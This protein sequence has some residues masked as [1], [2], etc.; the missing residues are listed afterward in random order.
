MAPWQGI[1]CTAAGFLERTGRQ[2]SLRSKK[3]LGVATFPLLILQPFSLSVR[4]RFSIMAYIV[5]DF[6]VLASA[7]P[8]YRWAL[9]NALPGK[10]P[11]EKKGC[12]GASTKPA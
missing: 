10:T 9:D 5:C 12:L 4:S 8:D 2:Q 7:M 1:G 3:I 6:E 11:E